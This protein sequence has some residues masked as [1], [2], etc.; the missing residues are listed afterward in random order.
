MTAATSE[1]ASGSLK[2]RAI[3][4]VAGQDPGQDLRPL[5]RRA[6]DEDGV[7]GELRQHLG[8]DRGV[9]AVG[10]LGDG[11]GLDRR[12]AEPADLDR[13]PGTDPAPGSDRPVERVV[14]QGP[15]GPGPFHHLVGEDGVEE[16][17]GV[18]GGAAMF[19]GA[20]QIHAQALRGSASSMRAGSFVRTARALA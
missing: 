11:A 6:V 4:Q 1:P 17:L 5:L 7:A 10:D 18:V 12:Q 15:A 16:R 13:P 19:V 9:P 3:E 20:A 2:P 8:H 14:V